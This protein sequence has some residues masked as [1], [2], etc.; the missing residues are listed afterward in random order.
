[1]YLRERERERE[2]A[3]WG[4]GRERERERERRERIPR[5]LCIVSTE[6]DTGSNPQTVRSR[7]EAKSD[8]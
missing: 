2:I 6:P 8:A 7:P 1:M 5:R 3:R 4:R